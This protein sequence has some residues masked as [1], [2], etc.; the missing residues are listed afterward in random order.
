MKC[1]VIGATGNVGSR[2]T[3]RLIAHGERPS[4][5]VRSA[6]RPRRFSGRRPISFDRWA[7]ENAD[8]FQ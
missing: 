5:F 8:A 7:E 6:R 4:V 2:V 3:R 1:L